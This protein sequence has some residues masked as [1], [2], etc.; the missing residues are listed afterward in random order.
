M[1]AIILSIGDELTLGQTVD[2]NAAWLSARLVERGII[3]RW[4]LTVP[5]DCAAITRAVRQA[6]EEAE[7]VIL[8]GGLGPT[9][10]DLTRQA[11]ADAL[12][13]PLAENAAALAG[14]EAY[15]KHRRW[16]M[17]ASNR[18]QALCPVGAECLENPCG[19]APGLKLRLDRAVIVSMPGV[20][21][22]M[23][24]MFD[25]HVAPLLAETSGRVIL[26]AILHTFGLGESRVGERL[27]EL[28][29]R[30]R[31]P[32]V[33]TTV[34]G[35]VV[36]VRIRSEFPTAAEAQ[37]ALGATAAEVRRRLGS[38]LYGEGE[39]TLPEVVGRLLKE[40][41]RTVATAESC[42]AGLVGKLLTDP[43]GAS[44]YYLG[45]WI[46]YANALK[47]EVLG[48]PAE[49]IARA[50]AVS[51]AV[52]RRMAEQALARSGADYALALT[53]VAGPKGGSADKPAGTVWIALARRKAAGPEVRAE[54][55]VFPGARDM[56]RER[57]AK[58]ALNILR[59][60]LLEDGL[61]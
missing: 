54:Q 23:K 37:A 24:A 3:T 48:V 36:S 20:P 4:H 2:T 29:D 33:G 10:D 27:G 19:T 55:F 32:K 26:T 14:I 1:Q 40:R 28:M 6:A 8:T 16:P 42:T 21:L 25:R 9:A 59:L 11:L 18:T 35:G 60:A 61:C 22:E 56:V 46:V 38:S 45:G 43:A 30:A 44:A 41:G 7:L 58:T 15:F 5:D 31:N 50:G 47:S 57:A 53:G 12:G 13:A 39:T 51:E 52:A 49:L 34:A 17:T